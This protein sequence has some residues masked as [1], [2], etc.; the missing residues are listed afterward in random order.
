MSESIEAKELQLVSIF[1]DSYRFEVPEYQR[2]YAWTT[3][4]TGELLDDIL[5]AMGKVEEVH[6]APPYFLGS[7]VIIKKGLRPQ[8]QIVDGQQRIA[9]LTILFCVLRELAAESDKSS[10]DRYVYE[11]GDKFAG[12][13]G[14]YR[15]AVR[16]RDN[17]FF[18]DNIQER[19][20][21]SAAVKRPLT[22]LPDSQRGMVQNAGY[23]MEA[24]AK[25]DERRRDTLMQFLVQRCYLVVVSTSDRN[26]AYRIFSVLNDRGLD[27]S[28]TDI[29]K[30]DIIGS[31]PKDSRA[32]N[33][34]VWE[35]IEED[36]GRDRFRDLFAH[37]RMISMKSR[38]QGTLQQ[39]FQEHVLKEVD[40]EAF[41][42]KVLE[43]YAEAYVTVTG[44][45]Y[46]RAGG[47]GEVNRYLRFLN[48]LDNFDW[49]PPAMAFFRRHDNDPDAI[50]RFVRDLERLA[51]KMFIM[52]ENINRRIQRYRSVLHSI[53][54]WEDL[55]AARSP[56]QLDP[57]EKAVL[58]RVLDGPIYMRPRVPRVLLLRLDTLLAEAGAS[59]EHPIITIEHVLPQN[60][61]RGSQWYRDF[62]D[63]EER[64]E[65]THRLANL[66]LLSRI[67]NSGASNYE[68]DYK[69][70]EY[71]QKGGAA[72]FV[73][74][75]SVRDESEWTPA[76]LARRQR[77]LIDVLTKEWRLE[78]ETSPRP[79]EVRP[80]RRVVVRSAYEQTRQ[81]L[82]QGLTLK[83]A[84]RQLG[85]PMS[86]V[87]GRLEQS[88][89]EWG[90]ID[91]R[92][93]LPPERFER[94]RPVLER[95]NS[96]Q[97]APAKEILGD[98]YANE[99]IRVVWL[100]LRQQGRTSRSGRLTA[101]DRQDE[102][103]AD[104]PAPTPPAQGTIEGEDQADAPAV[105]RGRRKRAGRVGSTHERTRQLWEQ[106]LSVEEIAEKRGL[107]KTTIVGHLGR[108]IDDGEEIDLRPLLPPP[109]RYAVIRRAFEESG[110]TLMA[111]VKKLVGDAYDYDEIKMVW[112]HLR[113]QGELP[114]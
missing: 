46:Q 31:L 89:Q 68:F 77:K 8:A 61:K 70:R 94:I 91:L 100:Y 49:I 3:E 37:I 81:L 29:L 5:R 76:V 90:E 18:R 52:R 95:T 105:R 32:H 75:A 114:E 50:F 112:I 106:G 60:P 58:L 67:K 43:P 74:T 21:L 42:E 113:R 23:L 97:L 22:G 38:A 30:A 86:T 107:A 14:H 102:R 92:G 83:Q 48:R 103:V 99:E 111:P 26:S 88:L 93:L 62:P 57:E 66:V 15:L 84:A 96:V 71:F 44:A 54:R 85:V 13:Q 63:D 28:P 36:L 16:G 87:L 1:D 79:R 110:G 59:Y 10:I 25:L 55:S 45:T 65:W 2:P 82:Q 108:L 47:S 39:E 34:A 11:P 40:R 27:L 109:E 4:Q 20:K 64:T 35:E 24:L 101:T 104:R 51:Y 19:G 98:D 7:I 6:D 69:K 56:L 41:I 12:I 53:Q 73:L 9:T 78:G 80:E 17:S 72:A 33:T